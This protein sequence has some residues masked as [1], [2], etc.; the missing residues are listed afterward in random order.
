MPIVE[1]APASGR[2]DFEAKYTPG[3]T[4]E[5]VPARLPEALTALAQRYAVE[6]HRALGCEGLTR[7]DMIV[8]GEDVVVLEVNTLPGLTGTS[9]AP[10][11]AAAA[12]LSFS[13]L[14]EW[15]V[16]EALARHAQA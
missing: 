1:I 14:V 4:E 10:N 5:I 9:L 12:G 8:R 11:S 6:A 2:Y 7:T 3:A 15:I 16:Q 13:D